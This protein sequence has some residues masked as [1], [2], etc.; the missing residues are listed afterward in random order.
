VDVASNRSE[1]TLGTLFRAVCAPAAAATDGQLL[2]SFLARRDEAA[3]TTLV[4]RHGPMVLGVCRRILGNVADADDAFQAAFLVLVRKAP[5]LRTRPV[6]GDWLHGVAR[7]TALKARGAAAHRRVKEL[8]AARPA[9]APGERRNDWLPL[10]DETLT[11]LPEKYR[12]PIVLCDLEGK[13][14]REAAEQLGWPSGTVAGRLARGRALLAKRLLQGSQNL[15]G[16][17]RAALPA[18]LVQ[19]TVQAAGAVSGGKEAASFATAWTLAQGVLQTMFWNKLKLGALVLL[20]VVVIAG[21]LTVHVLAGGGRLQPTESPG[22]SA[23]SVALATPSDNQP[24]QDGDRGKK[25]AEPK[26]EWNSSHKP[27]P[28]SALKVELTPAATVRRTSDGLLLPVTIT[29]HSAQD[30][31]TSLAHEWHGGEWPPTDLYAAVVPR[32]AAKERPLLPAYLS[33]ERPGEK[34]RSITIAPGWSVEVAVRMDWP[35]TGSQPAEPLMAPARAGTYDVRFLLVFV[36]EG[37]RQYAT[38]AA[39]A[40]ELPPLKDESNGLSAKISIKTPVPLTE[41]EQVEGT[42]QLTNVTDR[43]LRLYPRG[44]NYTLGGDGHADVL[45]WPDYPKRK[46]PLSAEDVARDTVT[47]K[48]Q[49]STSVPIVVGGAWRAVKGKYEIRAGYEVGK[50]FGANHNIWAGRV[51]ATPVVLAVVPQPPKMP[52]VVWS[53]GDKEPKPSTLKVE[54][55]AAAQVQRRAGGLVLPVTITN[56]AA[57]P[58]TTRPAHE[59]HGG[60]WPPTDLYAAVTPGKSAQKGRF[61]PVFRFGESSDRTKPVTIAPGKSVE[62]ELRMDWPG[63]GSVPA[64]PLIEPND[65]GTYRVFFLLAFEAEGVRQFVTSTANTVELPPPPPDEQVL[66]GTWKVKQ[67]DANGKHL[68][69]ETDTDQTWVITDGKIRVNYGDGSWD[70][71]AFKLDPKKTP[72]AIDVKTIAGIRSDATA[73]GIYDLKGDTFRVYLSWGLPPRRPTEFDLGNDRG[74]RYFVLER[75][76][77]QAIDARVVR[78]L[79]LKGFEAGMPTTDATQP[80]RITS[81]QELAKAFPNA[82]WQARI[83][84]QVDFTREELLFFAWSGPSAGR[85]TARVV[86]GKQGPEVVFHYIRGDGKDDGDHFHLYA[87]ARETHWRVVDDARV[88]QGKKDVPGEK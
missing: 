1:Q 31:T 71:W 44:V 55:A 33:G 78:E 6:L 47:L 53:R 16:V 88:P 9:S 77:Q 43:P 32:R 57:V 80:T 86:K 81:K 68:A 13:T 70:Q 23:P 67:A 29:N 7:R 22:G 38:G 76:P 46:D 5:A 27:P 19:A 8:A 59:W 79:S 18:G 83:N 54:V 24:I 4:R 72:R 21:G 11:R 17:G 48:P 75:V 61:E 62:F 36:A 69:K 73:I 12:L 56:H 45:V 3:F 85:L 64:A 41:G 84:K 10:L 26:V 52:T 34:A 51:D 15:S 63:T 35:G 50:E 2:E 20:S 82:A 60:L 40:V 65:P 28:P 74:G 39:R 42:L 14:L 49:E 66:R 58:I 37:K 87:I 25:P 30:I